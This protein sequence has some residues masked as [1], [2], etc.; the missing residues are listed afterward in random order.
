MYMN[1]NTIDYNYDYN[2]QYT[3]TEF[4][5]ID[6][7]RINNIINST[8][9]EGIYQDAINDLNMKF[10]EN[11][12]SDFREKYR[13]GEDISD[14]MGAIDDTVSHISQGYKYRQAY[15]TI[16]RSYNEGYHFN[17]YNNEIDYNN[18]YRNINSNNNDNDD[19]SNNSNENSIDKEV[20]SQDLNNGFEQRQQMR[21]QKRLQKK[22]NAEKKR[23]MENQKREKEKRERE[24]KE[25][26]DKAN[27]KSQEKDTLEIVDEIEIAKDS[28]IVFK[29]NENTNEMY[30]QFIF[31]GKVGSD[32]KISFEEYKTMKESIQK[33]KEMAMSRDKTKDKNYSLE[34]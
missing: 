28:I 33:Q 5:G 17:Q 13:A 14:L 2:M 3:N 20:Q 26:R 16:E 12:L 21:E 19:W 34:R 23:E 1:A 22:M 27:E 30:K 18:Q 15:N 25:K 7:N 8:D 32:I 6:M 9:L 4:D 24:A 29:V 11:E 31:A 10:S